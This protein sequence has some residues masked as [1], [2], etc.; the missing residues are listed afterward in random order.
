[1]RKNLY[2]FVIFLYALSFT[3]VHGV[4][5]SPQEFTDTVYTC[6]SENRFDE[7]LGWL[8]ATDIPQTNSRLKSEKAITFPAAQPD[9]GL[10][11]PWKEAYYARFGVAHQTKAFLFAG[12]IYPFTHILQ[13][14]ALSFY[15]LSPVVRIC[16]LLSGNLGNPTA[17]NILCFEHINESETEVDRILSAV[18]LGDILRTPFAWNNIKVMGHLKGHAKTPSFIDFVGKSHDPFVLLNGYFADNEADSGS[19]NIAWL[20][21][22]MNLGSA[23]ARIRL[24]RIGQPF[25]RGMPTA[26]AYLL[27]QQASSHRYVALDR[28]TANTHYLAALALIPHDPFLHMEVAGFYKD[29]SLAGAHNE[30]GMDQ[31]TIIQRTFHHYKQAHDKGDGE[32]ALEAI[33][34]LKLLQQGGIA[35]IPGF[36]DAWGLTHDNIL[37]SLTLLYEAAYSRREEPIFLD[38]I[39]SLG[40]RDQTYIDALLHRVIHAVNYRSSMFRLRT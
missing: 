36:S 39:K 19:H 9:P 33:K 7:F 22:A 23:L 12:E 1:M 17:N 5:R 32:A 20:T 34:F 3:H 6:C 28:N 14:T 10:Y 40:Q 27:T 4:A 25:A 11:R 15:E 8:K 24:N 26:E 35:L 21:E 30:V 29:L 18:D 37:I 13:T 38:R 16:I 2:F 31:N